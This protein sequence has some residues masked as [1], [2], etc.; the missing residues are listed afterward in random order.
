MADYNKDKVD[1][2]VLALLYLNAFDDRFG[3]RAW[4]SFDWDAM[5]RLHEKA[6]TGEIGSVAR[7][8][9][10]FM[11]ATS[12]EQMEATARHLAKTLRGDEVDGLILVPV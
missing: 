1:E 6:E 11:G 4:K 7:Y 3:A 10:S 12:P 8:H 5:D 9:Y 2:V